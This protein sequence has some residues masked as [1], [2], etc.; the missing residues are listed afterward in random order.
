MGAPPRGEVGGHQ[1]QQDGE[2]G[3]LVAGGAA[4]LEHLVRAPLL[5]DLLVA[6]VEERQGGAPE[7]SGEKAHAEEPLQAQRGNTPS[8]GQG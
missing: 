8:A 2:Q 4:Q 1:R 6:V 3:A 7:Q 5:V